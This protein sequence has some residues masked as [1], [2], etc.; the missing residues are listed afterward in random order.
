[1]HQ[2]RSN[3]PPLC[4]WCDGTST[5]IYS[6][7]AR[8]LVWVDR[9]QNYYAGSG[10][11]LD[12]NVFSPAKWTYKLH[13]FHSLSMSLRYPSVPEL[14]AYA[15]VV[16][17]DLPRSLDLPMG[18]FLLH[19][20]KNRLVCIPVR[21]GSEMCHPDMWFFVTHVE[22]LYK[23]EGLCLFSAWSRRQLMRIDHNSHL[24]DHRFVSYHNSHIFDSRSMS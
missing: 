9:V 19:I 18:S 15:S 16:L 13:V 2:K 12:Y 11:T 4:R 5:C 10:P 17:T 14:S 20:T 7:S 22:Y 21:F 23:A 6:K 3:S 24:C 1:M 8:S